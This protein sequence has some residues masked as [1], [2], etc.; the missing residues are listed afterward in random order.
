MKAIEKRI[1]FH[2]FRLDVGIYPN[3]LKLFNLT[4]LE[5]SPFWKD[6]DPM[7]TFIS[8]QFLCFGFSF[9][10]MKHLSIEE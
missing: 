7:Y 3:D 10:Y 1:Y 2:G 6:P 9:W 5:I 8:I 4:L